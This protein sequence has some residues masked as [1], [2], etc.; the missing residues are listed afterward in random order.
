MCRLPVQVKLL[1]VLQNR[2]V[3]RVGGTRSI[4]VDVRVIAGDEAQT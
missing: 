2:T 3:E 1:R 4:P